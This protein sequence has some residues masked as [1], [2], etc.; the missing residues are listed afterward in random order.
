M[1][2]H[3]PLDLKNDQICH[4]GGSMLDDH[5]AHPEGLMVNELLSPEGSCNKAMNI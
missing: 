2:I 1:C 3:I 5:Q 4:G